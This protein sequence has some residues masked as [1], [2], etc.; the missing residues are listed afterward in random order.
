MTSNMTTNP[1]GQKLAED[2]K[3]LLRANGYTELTSQAS[4]DSIN[5]SGVKGTAG[6]VFHMTA[7]RP[8]KASSQSGGG[9]EKDRATDV[10]VVPTVPGLREQMKSDPANAAKLLG[11]TPEL[12]THILAAENAA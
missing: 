11:L 3:A 7:Q 4:D 1:A 10:A 8:G 12:V 2:V 5:I 6:V 9:L